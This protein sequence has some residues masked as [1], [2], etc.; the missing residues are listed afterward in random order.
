MNFNCPSCKQTSS[1]IT[2]DFPFCSNCGWETFTDLTDNQWKKD[3]SSR[4]A[5]RLKWIED[6]DNKENKY[7]KLKDDIN[8]LTLQIEEK[9]K[10]IEL[11]QQEIE[12]KT[13]KILELEN[14]FKRIE[15]S[16]TIVDDFHLRNQKAN[17]ER[18]A[19]LKN[20]DFF[21]IK[22]QI[23]KDILNLDIDRDF[24][25][26]NFYLAVGFSKK[27][28]R[29]IEEAQIVFRIKLESRN[30]M[31][32]LSDDFTWQISKPLALELLRKGDWYVLISPMRNLD[33]VEREKIRITSLTKMITI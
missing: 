28:M 7:S 25:Y 21:T 31:S 27:P 14:E 20:R 24:H 32:I 2:I 3:L 1:N 4:L 11:T 8:N 19:N 18:I 22:A 23:E 26:E 10:E 33:R 13:L 5:I 12:R 15:Q 30:F 16:N 6:A 17:F 9:N 29:H